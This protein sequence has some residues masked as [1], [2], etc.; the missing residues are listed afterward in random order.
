MSLSRFEATGEVKETPQ[1]PQL[2]AERTGLLGVKGYRVTRSDDQE[3]ALSSKWIMH[4]PV[5]K[6]APHI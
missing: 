1:M 5:M 4:Q 6:I 2:P 3:Q